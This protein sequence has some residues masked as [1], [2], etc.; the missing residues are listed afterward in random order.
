MHYEY[1]STLVRLRW[2]PMQVSHGNY[3]G[4]LRYHM[5][6]FMIEDTLILTTE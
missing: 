5:V 1:V 4:I 6:S 3:H 2:E